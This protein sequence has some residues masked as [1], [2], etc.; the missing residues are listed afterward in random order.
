MNCFHSLSGCVIQYNETFESVQQVDGPRVNTDFNARSTLSIRRASSSADNSSRR[1]IDCLSK[2][3]T[4][5][6]DVTN[7]T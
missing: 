4:L 7:L 2:G 5:D 3:D 1:G 6:L